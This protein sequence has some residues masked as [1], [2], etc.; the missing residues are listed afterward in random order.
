MRNLAIATIFILSCFL[1]ACG[2]DAAETETVT[3][4]LPAVAESGISGTLVI[5]KNV[6]GSATFHVKL[7]GT[8]RGFE[9]PTHLHYGNLGVEDADVAYLLNPTSGDTG[10]SETVV[11]TLSDDN[12]VTY[13]E[14]INGQFSLKIHL[15]DDVDT[16]NTILAASNVGASFDE[17]GSSV[18]AVCGTK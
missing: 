1:Y 7:D 16:K 4:D 6:D 18:I 10:I 2:P 17:Y 12:P 13:E 14:I 8:I 15:G 3:Y 9:Y 11:A 5:S